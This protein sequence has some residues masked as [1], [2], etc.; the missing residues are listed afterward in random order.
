LRLGVFALK[1]LR[2]DE[3]VPEQEREWPQKAAA[4]VNFHVGLEARF[5]LA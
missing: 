1:N 5:R 2:A 4:D 3:I